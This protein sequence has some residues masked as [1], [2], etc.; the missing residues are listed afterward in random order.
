[1]YF[2]GAGGDFSRCDWIG[3]ISRR[4]VEAELKQ[5]TAAAAIATVNVVYPKAGAPNQ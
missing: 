3:F 2:L 1:M 4:K 5:S